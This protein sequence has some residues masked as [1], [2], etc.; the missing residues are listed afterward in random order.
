MA[1]TGL[2]HP[3]CQYPADATSGDIAEF[4]GHLL[5]PPE[6]VRKLSEMPVEIPTAPDRLGHRGFPLLFKSQVCSGVDIGKHFR[7]IQKSELPRSWGD[8][9]RRSRKKNSRSLHSATVG[10][11]DFFILRRSLRSESSQE[12]LQTGIA[13]VPSAALGTGS[14]TPRHKALCLR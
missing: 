8:G 5:S 7:R 2:M 9:R 11:C 6:S 4:R 12:H 3:K 10:V 1:C 14:S 13:G